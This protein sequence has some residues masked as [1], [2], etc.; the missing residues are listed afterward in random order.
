[1]LR[2][3]SSSL[4]KYGIAGLASAALLVPLFAS[5]DWKD[6][7]ELGLMISSGNSKAQS[8]HVKQDTQYTFRHR[9][10][11]IFN[12]AFI[13]SKSDGILSARN[14]LLG[15]RYERDFSPQWR[16]FAA[17]NAESDPFAG[18][19]HRYNS[20]LGAK[21]FLLHEEKKIDWFLESGYRYTREYSPASVA[22]QKLRFYSE[23]N[24][25][26][27]GNSQTKLWLE[28]IPNLTLSRNWLLNGEFS[29]SVF[30]NQVFSLK[31]AYQVKYNNSPPQSALKRD[32]LFTTS[33]VAKL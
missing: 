30:L 32:E 9:N 17:Q 16:G 10:R 22:Y 14:W 1:M 18:F 3:F 8:F 24:R 19:L 4:K 25:T 28:Y 12:A 20:D 6:E 15:L 11:I 7:S 21:V 13:Q 33:L 23:A 2:G 29:F 27:E 31:T 5:A 26:W